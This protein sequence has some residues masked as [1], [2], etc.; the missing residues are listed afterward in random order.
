MKPCALLVI[1]LLSTFSYAKK[2]KPPSESE[3]AAITARGRMMAEY[4]VAAWHATD[5][6]QAAAKG[7]LRKKAHG[8]YVAQKG[9]KGWTVIFGGVN[10]KGDKY[11]ISYEA[12]Q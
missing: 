12:V 3:L 5:A 7:D 6:V 9:D 1:I 2:P 10:D 11:L 4:D 8:F